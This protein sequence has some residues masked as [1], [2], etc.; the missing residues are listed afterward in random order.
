MLLLALADMG[1][2]PP[3]EWVSLALECAHRWAGRK[4]GD[5]TRLGERRGFAFRS[6]CD[7]RILPPPG[8]VL[9]CE[10]PHPWAIC[11]VKRVG[12]VVLRPMLS[13]LC[14]P[15]YSPAGRCI[16]SHSPAPLGLNLARLI[17]GLDQSAAVS[18]LWAVS[19]FERQRAAAA[20]KDLPPPP[21]RRR[22]T[23]LTVDD[24]LLLAGEEVAAA[25]AQA[26]G[27][28]G[29]AVTVTAAAEPGA[30]GTPLHL[31][32]QRKWLVRYTPLLQVSGASGQGVGEA[33]ALDRGAGQAGM[34][35]AKR[36]LEGLRFPSNCDCDSRVGGWALAGYAP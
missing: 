3:R 35:Q 34:S 28:P 19:R 7:S 6:L 31:R 20:A 32:P 27:G 22:Q 1:H 17:P 18:V 2:T 14:L 12:P 25:A 33:C 9:R 29:G 4:D 24:V 13:V 30:G 36:R 11:R 26:W 21:P 23:S 10:A 5:G 15:F 8:W 16:C